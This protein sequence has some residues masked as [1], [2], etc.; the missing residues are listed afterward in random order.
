MP[1]THLIADTMAEIMAREEDLLP[2]CVIST[3][4]P[5]VPVSSMT[6]AAFTTQAYVRD[7]QHL[8]YC[9]QPAITLPL[10]GSDGTYWLAISRDVSTAYATW[11]RRAGSQYLWQLAGAR[12]PDVDGLLVFASVTVAGGVITAVTPAPGVTRAERWRTLAGLGTMAQQNADAVAITGGA[13]TGLSGFSVTSGVP[14]YLTVGL[15]VQNTIGISQVPDAG[16]ALFLRHAKATQLG[17]VIR[18]NDT[19]TLGQPALLL[20]NLAGGTVGSVT[21]TATATAYNT[22]SD[23]RLKEF[24]QTLIGALDVVRALRPVSF[25]WQADGSKGNG[26]LAHELMQIV[27]EAV[28]GEPDAVNEDGS[29]KPQGV[30]HSRLVPWL[31][32]A[33]QETLAA[34]DALTA[35]VTALE[36]ALGL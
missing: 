15:H 30:D 22:S 18:P 10:S 32:A 28:S 33:L 12:P 24:V 20:Q 17:I 19:D 1:N 4:W 7:G 34:L 26:F 5:T 6:L 11:T 35:R 16:V 2:A 13:V 25:H 21:T 3:T 31:T 27:P 29:I 8:V 14:V 9:D 23:V 36:E